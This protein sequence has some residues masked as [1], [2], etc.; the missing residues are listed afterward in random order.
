M[1]VVLAALLSGP[2]TEAEI[3]DGL[4]QIPAV[5]EELDRELFDYPTA[6]FRDVYV[7]VNVSIEGPRRGAYLCGFVNAKS[8]AGGYVGW[9]AFV[10]TDG[11]LEVRDAGRENILLD[12]MCGRD[13]P[14]DTTDRSA[15][16]TVS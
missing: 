12:A 15:L 14:R 11:L 13:D 9:T 5:R 6:R 16:L 1:L 7:T 2:I 10:A 8:R 3:A 4:S